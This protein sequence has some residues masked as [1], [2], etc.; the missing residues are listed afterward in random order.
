MTG[1]DIYFTDGSDVIAGQPYKASPI[2]ENCPDNWGGL[3]KC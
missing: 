1:L 3:V 2:T